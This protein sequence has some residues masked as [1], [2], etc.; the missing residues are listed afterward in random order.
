MYDLGLKPDQIKKF[1]KSL[2]AIN[3]TGWL[4]PE[5][6]WHIKIIN[7]ATMLP[8]EGCYALNFPISVGRFM[9]RAQRFVY[10]SKPWYIRLVLSKNKIMR[11]I[12]NRVFHMIISNYN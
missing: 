2:K 5:I 10:Y 8:V 11:K 12:K 1:E 6:E 7:D 9:V 3:D 4:L